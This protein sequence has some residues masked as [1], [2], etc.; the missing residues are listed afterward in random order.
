MRTKRLMYWLL[1]FAPLLITLFV[2]PILPDSIPA[3]YGANGNV[4][5]YG[6][7]YEMLIFPIVSVGMGVFFLLIEKVVKKD[8]EKSA[9]NAKVLY[10][11]SIITALV[12]TVQQIIFL[13]WAYTNAQNIY[14]VEINLM[15]VMAICLSVAYIVIGNLLPKC[16]Q[17]YIIGI[18]TK[19]TLESEASWYK[20]HRLGGK[21]FMVYGVLSALMSLFLFNGI[22][23]FLFSVVG[24]G[25]VVIPLILYSR[26]IYIQ[27]KD[28][29]LSQEE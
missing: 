3:H 1:A 25:V 6:S 13:R 5:R 16:K 11:S 7:K 22:I 27:E 21:T 2:L 15:K 29:A 9:L 19:W 10:W 23:A 4:T 8:L 12:F 24:I 18:R 26:Y 20:T 28:S 17:N 14:N